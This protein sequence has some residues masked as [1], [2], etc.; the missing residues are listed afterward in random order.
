MLRRQDS[1]NFHSIGFAQFLFVGLMATMLLP[2]VLSMGMLTA[3]AY[4]NVALQTGPMLAGPGIANSTANMLIFYFAV[5]KIL[6]ADSKR[7]GFASIFTRL[8]GRRLM[9]VQVIL[10]ILLGVLVLIEPAV[11]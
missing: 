11:V 3:P 10:C 7:T 2:I 4:I 5:A 8:H 6:G 1:G 9:Q